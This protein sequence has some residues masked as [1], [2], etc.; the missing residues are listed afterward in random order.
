MKKDYKKAHKRYQ[1]LS[2]EKNE[3]KKQQYS[4]ER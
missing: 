2:K 1:S 3:E 4:C